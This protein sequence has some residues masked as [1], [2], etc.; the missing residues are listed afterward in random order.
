MLL[1]HFC[2]SNGGG[3]E[4]SGVGINKKSLC[5]FGTIV[6]P[7]TPN[8]Q[9]LPI[10]TTKAF[11]DWQTIVESHMGHLSKAQILV[12]ALWSYGIVLAK[13]CGL[14]TVALALA[15]EFEGKEGNFRQRLREWC[16]DK[17]DKRGKSRADWKVS[18]SFSPLLKW[19]LS[20]WSPTVRQLVLAIDAT[21]LKKLFV[22]LSISVVYRG[23]AI[24]IAWAIL[25]EGQK[26]SWKEPWL[27]LF[28]CLRGSTPEDWLVLVAADRG[29]YARWLYEAIQECGWHP[30]L[31]INQGS[32]YR[33]KGTADFRRMSQLLP[34][35]G[36][37]W[38]GYV[39]CFMVHSVEGTLLACWGA[40]HVEPWIIL[41]DLP[42]DNASAAWYGMRSW[43]ENSFK[44]IKSDGWQWQNTRMSDPARA[45]RLWLALSVATLWVLSVGGEADEQ[46]SVYDLSHLPPTHIARKTHSHPSRTRRMSCFT[47]GLI[48]VLSALTHQRPIVLGRFLPEPWPS[49]TYP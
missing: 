3:W 12:L 48:L 29:L 16:W 25:P 34:A 45:S 13:T 7:N 5:M 39:T 41:T 30:F 23:C 43:I 42:P 14:S 24:P 19:I 4:L 36:S 11:L 47:R 32:L 35:P 22:V 44:D 46:V 20:M 2:S 37:L 10:N 31:R 8:K 40:K 15:S 49:H 27:E 21:S 38:A 6:S 28:R 26:G 17:Q 1:P 33:P 9:R 18:Q